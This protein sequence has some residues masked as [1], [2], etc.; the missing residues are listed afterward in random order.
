MA[1]ENLRFDESVFSAGQGKAAGLSYMSLSRLVKSGDL[2]RPVRGIYKVPNEPDDKLYVGQLRRPK[3]VYSHATAL[4][5]HDL[6]PSQPVSPSVTVPTGYNTKAL[7]KD[8]FSVFSVKNEFYQQDIVQ[9]ATDFGHKV[10]AYSVERTIVD[11]VRSRSRLDPDIY[12]LA[13]NNFAL[14]TNYNSFLLFDI[15]KKFSINH[16]LQSYLVVLIGE[17]F[18][19]SLSQRKKKYFY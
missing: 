1:K 6:V 3:I 18:Y 5:L 17:R 13:L 7:S 11:C 15:A 9:L 4:I 12:S 2:Q 14:N 16:L 10:Y 19:R 8:G